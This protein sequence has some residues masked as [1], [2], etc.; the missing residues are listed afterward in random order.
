MPFSAA[1]IQGC[2][3]YQF[4]NYFAARYLKYLELVRYILKFKMR[5][6]EEAIDKM[7]PVQRAK[8]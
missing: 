5:Q 1:K 4:F 3:R 2:L 7:A 8:L 6:G